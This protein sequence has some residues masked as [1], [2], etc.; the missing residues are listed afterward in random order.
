MMFLGTESPNRVDGVAGGHGNADGDKLCL[1]RL[2]SGQ[3]GHAPE[4]RVRRLGGNQRR[5]ID[6]SVHQWRHSQPGIPQPLAA[7]KARPGC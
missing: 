6:D 2:G 4:V 5:F 3:G 7:P 1:G